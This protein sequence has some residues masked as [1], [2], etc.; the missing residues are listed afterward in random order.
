MEGWCILCIE[1]HVEIEEGSL[2]ELSSHE[3]KVDYKDLFECSSPRER[4]NP[5]SPGLVQFA[6]SKKKKRIHVTI[7]LPILNLRYYWRTI[8][9]LTT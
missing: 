4:Q 6:L 9:T 5:D 2:K 1:E 8:S 7:S 3:V